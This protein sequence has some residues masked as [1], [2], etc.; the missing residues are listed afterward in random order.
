M[1]DAE[2]HGGCPQLSKQAGCSPLSSM[3]SI[4]D[5]KKVS[6]SRCQICGSP[7]VWGSDDPAEDKSY[8]WC[9]KCD[10]GPVFFPLYGGPKP[11]GKPIAEMIDADI[12]NESLRVVSL[13]RSRP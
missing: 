5:D 6:F 12:A 2:I 1:Q 9:P 3:V 7:L 8:Y 13:L 11:F 4:S 10:Y